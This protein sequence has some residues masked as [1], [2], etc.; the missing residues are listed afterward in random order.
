MATAKVISQITKYHLTLDEVEVATMLSVFNLVGGNP[1]TTNR[2]YIDNI[3]G[4]L[5]LCKATPLVPIGSTS[6]II[7]GNM[8]FRDNTLIDK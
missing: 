3:I 1:S 2:K 4:A 7:E 8:G 5:I 6:T